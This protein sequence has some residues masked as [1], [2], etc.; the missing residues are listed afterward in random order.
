MTLSTVPRIALRI[1]LGLLALLFLVILSV[2][3]ILA[4]E[5]GRLW[6]V[7]Q[8]IHFAEKAGIELNLEEISSP[9]LGHW[10]IASVEVFMYGKALVQADGIVFRWLPFALLQRQLH[11]KQ[12]T[13]DKLHYIQPEPTDTE[14]PEKTEGGGKTWPVT[15]EQLAVNELGI[16]D[17]N[18]EDL[19]PVLSMQA[20][21]ELFH[22]DAPVQ[23]DALITTL[24]AN[25]TTLEV[26]TTVISP[27]EIRLTGSIR[28]IAG[29]W[30]AE[31]LDLPRGQGLDAQFAVEVTQNEDE[32]AVDV[33]T[34][35]LPF[36]QHQLAARGSANIQRSTRTIIIK[37]FLLDIDEH[38]QRVKGTITPDD[39]WLDVSLSELPL[40]LAQPWLPEPVEGNISGDFKAD[41]FFAG[42]QKW[43][44]A[45]GRT[46]FDLKV[47]EQSV[48]GQV[49]G[50]LKKNLATLRPSWIMIE[51][52]RLDLEGVFDLT[53]DANAVTARLRN[54]DSRLL[55]PWPVPWP[56]DLAV[57]NKNLN[58]EFKGSFQKPVVAAAGDVRA[59]YRGENVAVNLDGEASL[60]SAQFRRLQVKAL[61]SELLA[62]G[63][64][65]WEGDSTD[66]KARFTRLNKRLMHFV[67]EE[68]H[69]TVPEELQFD[70]S[71]RVRIRGKL[72]QPTVTADLVVDGEYL[73][74]EQAIPFSLIAD[75]EVA[76]APLELLKMNVQSLELKLF[77][78]PA[79]ALRGTFSAE[80]MALHLSMSRLPTRA[81]AAFG[82][83][84]LT[85]EAEAELSLSGKLDAPLLQGQIGY[86]KD[87]QYQRRGRTQT[88]PVVLDAAF[89]Q[90]GEQL[91]LD[92]DLQQSR[93]SVGR[94]TAEIPVTPYVSALR[95]KTPL[96]LVGTIKG[97]LDLMTVNMLLDNDLHEF[98]G[99]LVL[100]TRL[101]GNQDAPELFGSIR[102]VDGA[103]E[104]A[105]AGTE[106]RE[107]NATIEGEGTILKMAS[108]SLQ[109][110][111]G[112]NISA[113]G[114]IDWLKAQTT[115]R[116]AIRFDV[117]AHKAQLV[118]RVD[119]AGEVNGDIA[120]EGHLK[121]IWVKGEIE[122]APLNINISAAGGSSIPSIDLVD[123]NAVP[124]DAQRGEES[125]M[126]TVHLD[127]RIFTEQQAYLRGRGLDTELHGE[128]RLSGTT[129]EPSYIG[130]FNTRRGRLDILN[131]RFTLTDGQVRFSN[132]VIGLNITGA[133]SAD[134]FDY[135]VRVSGTADEPK[136]QLSSTPALPEDQI[137]SRLIFGKSV[138]QIS[139]FQAIRLA[140]AVNSLR[141]GSSFDPID[142]MRERLG[143]DSLTVEGDVGQGDVSV[144]VGKYL[145]D[146]V[147]LELERSTNSNLPQPWQSTVQIELTPLLTLKGGTGESGSGG[148]ELLWARDY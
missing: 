48:R 26:K 2:V 25:Q 98:D 120:L 95:Q 102:M 124:E 114:H 97:D 44:N 47:R 72:T 32:I 105:I 68:F 20:S 37:D 117:N 9:D 144:G 131:K 111:G 66:L 6:L 128:I 55:K 13:A 45:D 17:Q 62:S 116:D 134:E 15:V 83:T 100:D 88:V 139:A 28:E 89:S 42:D 46:S 67:P 112:G 96:P 49:E 148:A 147:Y 101:K 81:L 38:R 12:L 87:L 57:A 21:A 63:R 71:G 145:S 132:D 138:Q 113:T 126:P 16:F 127:L 103:Y 10:E 143:I 136:L 129:A 33:E 36:L 79:A 122:V 61:D 8:G 142:N 40:S 34:L 19:V 14:K 109:T 50:V 56:A 11:V 82:V 35:T 64:L 110:P 52:T 5:A 94:V 41:W 73:E 78:Q 23:L 90:R 121:D 141:S 24:N 74:A 60:Q 135:E 1:L 106:L 119:V 59:N 27:Q 77:D 125:A 123:V 22:V 84:A 115:D 92:L 137:L 91:R 93:Q 80:A 65:D 69:E 118:N 130:E 31:Q 76:V 18:R 58:L 54:F 108:A 4:T 85:G 30:L 86:R 70:S 146:R 7:D 29:G 53:G 104:N 75:G 140:A 133:Y 43:P 107:I 99:R 39:L 51:E 3:V